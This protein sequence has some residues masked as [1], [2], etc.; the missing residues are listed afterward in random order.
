MIF[1]FISLCA[2]LLPFA[3]DNV[4]Q[5]GRHGAAVTFSDPT[6]R[7]PTILADTAGSRAVAMVTPNLGLPRRVKRAVDLSLI[8]YVT[9]SGQNECKETVE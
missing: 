8:G 9:V 4:P 6:K 7:E 3:P 1:S 5:L 2:R